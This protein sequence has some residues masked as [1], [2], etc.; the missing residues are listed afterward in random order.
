MPAIRPRALDH[1]APHRYARCVVCDHEPLLR[2]GDIARIP[3]WEDPEFTC[4]MAEVH[5]VAILSVDGEG[6]VTLDGKPATPEEWSELLATLPAR[7]LS[8][9]AIRASERHANGPLKAIFFE[10]L[11]RAEAVEL[12]QTYR[13]AYFRCC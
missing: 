10:P 8:A 9:A 1:Y 12:R 3:L 11:L 13:E 6:E 2:T 5:R 7:E 4:V